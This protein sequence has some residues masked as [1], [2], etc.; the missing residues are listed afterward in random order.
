MGRQLHAVSSRVLKFFP[1]ALAEGKERTYN[2]GIGITYMA[3][4]V[5]ISSLGLYTIVSR[6]YSMLAKLGMPLLAL[7]IVLYSLR[8][9]I[10]KKERDTSDAAE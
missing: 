8:I 4:C 9:L 2:L 5:A 1:Q 3:S 6:G 7:P 10:R